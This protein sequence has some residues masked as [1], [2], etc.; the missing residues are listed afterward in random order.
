ANNVAVLTQ[1]TANLCSAGTAGAIT[2]SGPWSWSCS[3]S[4]GGATASCAAGLADSPHFLGGSANGNNA[5]LV[6][7]SNGQTVT[8]PS[9]VC[10]T[11]PCL[12]GF[13]FPNALATGTSYNVTVQTQPSGQTCT[14]S[15]GSGVMPAANV[16]NVSVSCSSIPSY[17]LGGT[18]ANLTGSVLVLASN[19]QTV[20]LAAN[21]SSFTFPNGLPAGTAYNVTVQT[22]PSGQTCSVSLGSAVMPAAD[23]SSVSVTCVTTPVAIDGVCGSA[24]NVAVLTQPTANL[25]S[26]GSAGA[27]AGSGP[28]NWSCS[29]SNG[30]SSASCAAGLAVIPKYSV[31][32][33]ISGLGNA[34]GL[35]LSN[36]AAEDLPVA[37]NA[38]SFVFAT[39]L[40]QGTP[41]AVTVKTQ[42]GGMNCTVSLGSGVMPAANVTNVLV[43]CSS[44][45]SYKLGGTVANLTGSVLVL[46]NNGQTVGL[47]ANAGS[48]AFPNGLL[49]GTAY[50]VTVQTQPSGQTCTV[51]NGSGA[52]PA[53]DVSSVSV[54]CVPNPVNGVCGS[55]NNVALLTQPTANLCSAGIESAIFG[56]GPWSWICSGSSGGTTTSCAAP[57]ADSPHFLG[58]AASGN[59]AG[60]VLSSNGEA[61]A[62]P[63]SGCSTCIAG[64]A[65]PTALATGTAYNVTVQS[66]PSGQ[67]CTVSNGSGVMPAANVSNVTVTCV[68]TPVAVSGVCGSANNVAVLTQPTA[69]LCSAGSAGAVNGSGPWNW[70]CSGSNGGASASC[71]AGLAVTPKFSV[72]GGISGLGNASGLVLSNNAA[73]DLPVAANAGS[74]VFATTLAQ[75]TPYAVTVKTQPGGMNCTVSLGSGVMPAANV[76]NVLVSCSSIPSYKLG[77]TVA[78]LTGSV[79][80][81]AN[82]GQTVGLAANAGS[83][84]FPNG[85]LAGTAYNVT[86]QT[87]P[88]GQT[89]TVSNGSGAMP[90]ADVSS[91][92]VTCVT[93]PVAVSGVCGS[94]NNVAVLTQPTAN[95]CSAGSAGAVAGSGPWS[96][97]CT[98]SNGGATASCA[99]GLADTP[100]FLGGSASSNNAGLVLGSNGQTVAVTPSSCDPLQCS[101]VGF[102]FPNALATGTSYNVTVQTQPSGQTC[103]VSN[104]SGVMSAANV[105]NVLVACVNNVIPSTYTLTPTFATVNEGTAQTFTLNTTNVADGT[106]LSYTLSGTIN[107]PDVDVPLTGSVTVFGNAATL[108]ITPVADVMTEGT[109]TAT[110]AIATASSSLTIN[111]TSTTPVAS[112][113]STV[114]TFPVTDCVKD[115][116]TGLTWEGKPQSGLRASGNTYTNY[117]STTALQYQSAVAGYV[118]PTQSQIDAATNSIGYKNAVN[119]SVLCG[120]TDWRLPTLTELHGLIL[121]G[122]GPFT[123]DATWFPNAQFGYWTSTPEPNGLAD[124]AWFVNF[125]NG[126]SFSLNRD[127]NHPLRLVR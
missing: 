82:N 111:D 96:W 126:S 110:L 77:G 127:L 43:S 102:A 100:H 79:L 27:V 47:A 54:A 56:S 81:L 45:P 39:T 94:A 101:I 46:A 75:G 124:F 97:S 29:G 121:I 40:A 34:S 16:T 22:Q 26:A 31:S 19:G 25:C 90:A 93:T 89:C 48:F 99:A 62:V 12:A 108:T 18:V 64:F 119:A 61:V 21:A 83:F 125:L 65:F 112:R 58:G 4:N 118:A 116:T 85:L 95:L 73:E 66:L 33:G 103:T 32:G 17:K 106:Q 36:N 123:L 23:V 35:V 41:Y 117:D 1:P 10:V 7:S 6:L 14:V 37:A 86:V 80:V 50:N 78:N 107:A 70:S 115:T 24:N 87:Q 13:A 122:V 74:F 72:G 20:G 92:L 105:T 51:S 52:M 42:P 68:S 30:G 69:N 98:G 59:N 9:I 113:Y 38:G 57:L 84:A 104:G 114:G 60:L 11:A 109:E 120:Y 55:A 5:G 53:A 28:W 3:D 88:S 44:I 91:V 2:G 63:A 76:T 71:A 49:A 15:N 8:V 67:T